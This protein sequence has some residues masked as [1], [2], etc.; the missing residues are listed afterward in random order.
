M[1][2]AIQG[3]PQEIRMHEDR[4]EINDGTHPVLV[5]FVPA[6]KKDEIEKRWRKKVKKWGNKRNNDDPTFVDDAENDD[7]TE[8]PFDL[9]ARVKKTDKDGVRLINA[10]DL[11]G[12]YL[13]SSDHPEIFENFREIVREFAVEKSIE[14]YE[15][16]IEEESD[17]LDDIEDD[18]EDL[19][20]EKEDIEETIEEKKAV[21]E[22]AKEAIEDAK[23][24]LEDLEP[25]LKEKKKALEAQQEVIEK[26]RSK[27]DEID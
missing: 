8:D 26:I 23:E 24:D 3:S 17:K 27:K 9:Y 15:V 21:I 19:Q 25:N 10:I 4:M 13:T 6:G 11:G 1:L 18:H 5:V 16:R 20:D 12:A 22:E 14:A 2:L 7:I